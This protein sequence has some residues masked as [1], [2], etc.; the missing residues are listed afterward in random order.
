MTTAGRVRSIA[1]VLLIV[2]ATALP[3][4]LQTASAESAAT[5]PVPAALVQPPGSIVE[6]VYEE[7]LP[8][9]TVRQQASRAFGRFGMP[10]VENDVDVY[11]LRFVTTGLGGEYAVVSASLFVP[12]DPP[13]G[14]SPLYVYGSG[15]TGLADVCAPS[16]EA[17]LPQ[18]L[19]DYRGLLAAYAA[20]GIATIF[21]DYLGFENPARPQAYF[22]AASEAHVMLD[23]A[24]AARFL[25]SE[26]PWLGELQDAVLMGGYSQGGH[27]AFAAADL[28]PW[29]AP[30][31]PLLGMVGYGATTD[32]LPLF[33][34]GPYYAPY[35]L[36]SWSAIYGPDQVD[37][38]SVLRERWLPSLDREALSVCVDR[39]QQIFPFDVDA[40]YTPAFARALR[41]GTLP[42]YF[43]GIY[44]LFQENR[45]GLSGH[46]LPA[47]VVQGGRDVI[48][49]DPTQERFVAELCA[50]GSDVE[51][52][53]V[54]DAR[55]RETRPA[56]F[57][58]SVRWILER[59]AGIPA[60]ST[61]TW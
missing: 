12:V 39:A 59:S 3:T 9:A 6:V 43:P 23:A 48:V 30:E 41:A 37:A 24:R 32:V 45:T 8:R 1:F 27:A 51:Y 40:M 29:Y 50:R 53:N 25:F 7:R 5:E 33:E 60:P 10:E 13:R 35:V 54:P 49:H 18:P 56:G 19:G 47:L 31:L 11:R 42:V 58:A 55:H 61:C 20:R 16:R 4:S 21:P 34:E 2:L 15:T 38:A 57:E 22:H 17:A 44:A 46:G 52:F 26:A 14:A 36:A 28:R